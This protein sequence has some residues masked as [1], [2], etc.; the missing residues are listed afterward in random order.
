MKPEKALKDTVLEDETFKGEA[1][2]DEALKDKALQYK[3]LKGTVLIVD[4]NITNL[5]VLSTSLSEF[6]LDVLVAQ[7]GESAL[8]KIRYAQPDLILLDVMMPGIDGFE[9]CRQLK[10]D[11]LYQSVP[12]IFMTA[13]ADVDN[14]V[15]GL[16]LGAVDYISKPFHEAEVVSRV[17]IHLR[18]HQLNRALASKNQQLETEMQ[19]SSAY[20]ERL[21]E[22]LQSLQQTQMQLIQSEKMSALGQMVAGIA[23]EINNPINFI[24]GNLTPLNHY[25]QD[26]SDLL[27]LYMEQYPAPNA[28]LQ[29]KLNEVDISF[30]QADV[31]KI[32][33]SME[34]GTRR[35][36]EIVSS[37]QNFSHHD[38]SECKAIDLHAGL[39]D[40]IFILQHRLQ[41]KDHRPEIQLTKSYGKIP[42]IECYPKLLNQVFLHILT[43]AIDALSEQHTEPTI[44]ITTEILTLEHLPTCIRIMIADNG[45]GISAELQPQIFNPFF[46]TRAIGEGTGLGLSV[47][48]Q[49]V[50]GQHGGCLKCVSQ[51]G[52]GTQMVIELPL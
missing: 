11:P 22:T 14:K 28:S 29:E 32:L 20:A 25:I 2:K 31:Q 43:N 21:Q 48:H 19:A 46:T 38:Q 18:L 13:L 42:N 44:T 16:S 41:P 45:S 4:D 35:V 34:T 36:Q 51:P 37:L 15:K 17:S 27:A 39:D 33:K 52:V 23:H 5:K 7:S 9:T 10:T 30:V 26:F 40:A 8:Q 24:H 50:V 1:L 47:S 6:G 49:I 3:A 12:V